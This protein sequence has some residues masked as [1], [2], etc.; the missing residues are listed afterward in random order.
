MDRVT[1]AGFL[2]EFEKIAE[3]PGL[4]AAVKSILGHGASAAGTAA[5]G[6]GHLWEAG[7]KGST[8]VAEHLEGTGSRLGRAAG[9]AA[10][11]APYAGAMY[12]A[13]KVVGSSPV[14]A[15]RARLSGG[16]DQGG[17]YQ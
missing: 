11:L 12:G 5:K 4:G 7:R 14:Q 13:G 16:G 2:S 15:V 17:Y 9:G 3:A 6:A 1:V 10:R 8:A